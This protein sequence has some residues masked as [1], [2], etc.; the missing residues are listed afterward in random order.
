MS[1]RGVKVSPAPRPSTNIGGRMSKRKCP[2][3]GARANQINENVDDHGSAA[4]KDAER[5]QRHS[6]ARLNE[7]ECGQ[8]QYCGRT[9][10]EG[11]AVSPTLEARR[12]DAAHDQK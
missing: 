10:A 7:H 5:H 6:G 9:A 4:P 8:R 2:S 3:R 12:D 11:E 1:A